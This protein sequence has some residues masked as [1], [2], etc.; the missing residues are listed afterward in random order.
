MKITERALK[1]AC[2]DA[3][4]KLLKTWSFGLCVENDGHSYR[5][6]KMD[7]DP[8]AAI[9][10]S[11]LSTMPMSAKETMCFIEGFTAA[12]ALANGGEGKVDAES[13]TI[14]EVHQWNTWRP[15]Q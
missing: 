11:S 2:R 4:L 7:R 14:K 15:S 6:Y 8:G 10:Y 12:V 3:N 5:L 9:R 1:T 13:Q